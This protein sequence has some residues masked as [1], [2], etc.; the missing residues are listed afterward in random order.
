MYFMSRIYRVYAISMNLKHRTVITLTSHWSGAESAVFSRS[1]RWET[2]ALRTVPISRW[3]APHC[4]H[5]G[6]SP[7]SSSVMF[8]FLCWRYKSVMGNFVV[9]FRWCFWR[10]FVIIIG[11]SNDHKRR[12]SSI[13]ELTLG[14]DC[15]EGR[16]S[17]RS[18]R[19]LS[20]LKYIIFIEQINACL[21]V[22]CCIRTERPLQLAAFP[23]IQ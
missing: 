20:V 3:A 12:P 18:S 5:L 17:M 1:A 14:H 7:K 19:C 23:C 16:K 8:L 22:R 6:R 15:V 9:V 11:W 13:A 10:K 2:V 4:H 21:Y